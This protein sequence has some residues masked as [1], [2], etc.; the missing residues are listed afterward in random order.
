MGTEHIVV[1][2]TAPHMDEAEAIATKLLE[3][4]LVA[5]ANLVPGLTSLF[6]WEGKID[7]AEEVLM[8]MKTTRERLEHVTAMV[9]E[10]W[11]FLLEEGKLY[12]FC[13][14]RV[15]GSRSR[16]ALLRAKLGNLGVETDDTIR[17]GADFDGFSP[18]WEAVPYRSVD[19]VG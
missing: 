18:P 14:R 17:V 4:K 6:W 5:C 8:V 10:E 1:L 11:A 16:Y 19:T 15:P 2:V 9:E 13:D 3:A 7:R 12:A